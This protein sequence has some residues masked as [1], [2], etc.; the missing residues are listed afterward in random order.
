M[1]GDFPQLSTNERDRRWEVAR[2]LIEDEDI[3]ALLVFG[4]RDGAGSALWA[5]DHWMTN[6]RVGAN[7][8]FPRGGKPIAHV[9]ST[10]S[11]TD[12]MESSGRGEEVWLAPEQFRLGRM[13][14][15]L[16]KTIEAE[17]LE[18]ARF[19][20]VGIDPMM[21]FFPDGIVPYGTYHGVVE[22]LP[23][24]TFKSVGAAYGAVSTLRRSEEELEM[25]RKCAQTAESM[26]E[27][28]ID[29]ARVGAT[30]AD[31]LAAITAAGVRGGCWAHWT[32]LA[33]GDENLSWGA[34][35]WIYRGGAPR[36]I[37]SG[38]ILL[39]EVMPF[40]GIY[41]TQQQLSIAFG[42][43]H[44]DMERAAT[45]CR[46][47]YDV[48]VKTLR[49]GASVFGEVDQAMGAVI[50]D[51]GGWNLTPNIHSLPHFG[52][53]SFGPPDEQP[54]M[55]PYPGLGAGAHPGAGADLELHPGIVFAVQ[56]NCVFGRRRM[57]LGGTV[58]TTEDGVEELN[59]IPNDLV[60]VD[61]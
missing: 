34:P 40:Y 12:H 57:N 9:W 28:A 11:M 4:D 36:E 5:T 58:V 49:D 22:G 24:A 56:P 44:P 16:L 59:E 51:A 18:S 33:D 21:P 32:I 50:K 17:G 15:S 25:L 38:D 1:S 55:K 13:A 52:L 8:L 61:K 31:L 53:G 46:E 48:A 2:Q 19:G 39:F 3:D 54:E 37:K 26:C 41:E 43:I 60:R 30:D 42:E 14:A 20:V 47:S 29:V 6:D 7:V 27:A 10:N 23:N 35:S 45:V